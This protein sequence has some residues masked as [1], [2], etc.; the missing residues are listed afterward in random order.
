MSDES[1]SDEEDE[2]SP[3]V[4]IDMMRAM[5]KAKA[6]K[7]AKA[8]GVESVIEVQNLNSGKQKDT[9]PTRRER[10]AAEKARKEAEYRR[11]HAAGKT[12]EARKDLARLALIRKRRADDARR[13][14]EE[15]EAEVEKAKRIAEESADDEEEEVS[16][17]PQ[18]TSRQIKGMNPTKL[19]DALKE[20][21]ESIQGSKKILQKRLIDWCKK[22]Q[23]S[24]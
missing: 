23:K 9:G 19:K 4:D 15:A 12:E 8:K 18:L 11:L 7:K 5:A 6:E 2:R 20:R 21:N 1:S 16:D 13:K 24:C 22:N 14:K 3:D 10:E 17:L